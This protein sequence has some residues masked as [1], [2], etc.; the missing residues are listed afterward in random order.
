MSG[1]FLRIVRSLIFGN[2]E[3]PA[4]DFQG[5]PALLNQ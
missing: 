1:T 4:V 5:D 2:T 3:D